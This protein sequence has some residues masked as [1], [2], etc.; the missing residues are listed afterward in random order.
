M[1]L[2]RVGPE[3]VGQSHCGVHLCAGDLV[4]E[5]GQH[6]ETDH[7]DIVASC[8]EEQGKYGCAE[9]FEEEF[10]HGELN[11]LAACHFVLHFNNYRV[12]NI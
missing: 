8:E 7:D 2:L 3:H 6:P 12:L 10:A 5:D 1:D 9:A 4:Q 11:A